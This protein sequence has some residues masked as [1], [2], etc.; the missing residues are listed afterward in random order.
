MKNY[1][2]LLLKLINKVIDVSD[3]IS[4]TLCQGRTLD[5][6]AHYFINKNCE[7][8]EI[9]FFTEISFVVNCSKLS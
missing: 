4:I 2:L 1:A 8:H 3:Q 5:N 9:L 6:L 7:W